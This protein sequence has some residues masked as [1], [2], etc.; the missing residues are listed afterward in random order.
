MCCCCVYGCSF[1]YEL[2]L[3]LDGWILIGS[4]LVGII[5]VG[6]VWVRG[7]Y[8]MGRVGSMVAGDRGGKYDFLGYY[9]DDELG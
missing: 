5:C 4:D 3:D 9:G 1:G 8:G 7:W 2:M 6:D